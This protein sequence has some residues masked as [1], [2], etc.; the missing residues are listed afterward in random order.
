M[1]EGRWVRNIGEDLFGWDVHGKTLGLVGFG[2]IGQAVAR[3]G[4]LG[5]GMPVLFHNPFE[6]SV[7]E[8]DG[9]ATRAPFEEVLRRFGVAVVPAVGERFDPRMHEAVSR[10]ESDAVEAPT[11]VEEMQRGYRLHDRLLRPAMVRVAVPAEQGQA[12]NGAAAPPPA[13]G[14]GEGE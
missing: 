9:R 1:R 6:V 10:V 8:L 2:R 5:F 4:A 13:D 7:P 11:V 3:R 14:P 12:A